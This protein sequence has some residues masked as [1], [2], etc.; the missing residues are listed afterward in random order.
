M[1]DV[2]CNSLVPIICSE[3]LIVLEEP[4]TAVWIIPPL[5]AV[6]G[7][8]Q[9][10]F[11]SSFHSCPS[12]HPG[13]LEFVFGNLSCLCPLST[14]GSCQKPFGFSLRYNPCS[15]VAKLRNS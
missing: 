4:C 12:S 8:K 10:F 14:V 5:A 2:E 6:S 9:F 7:D 3:Y 11:R 13:V 1:R 15:M